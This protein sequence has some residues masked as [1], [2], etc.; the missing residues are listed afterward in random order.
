MLTSL[1]FFNVKPAYL[2]ESCG[3]DANIYLFADD[4]TVYQHISVD[5]DELKLQACVDKFVKCA[6]E[7]LVKINYN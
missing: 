2:V 7:W 3:Q 6:E 5:D 4:V 1:Q